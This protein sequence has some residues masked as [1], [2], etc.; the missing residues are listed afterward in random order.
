MN[1]ENLALLFLKFCLTILFT[2]LLI[3]S[4]QPPFINDSLFRFSLSYLPYGT[5]ISSCDLDCPLLQ[6]SITASVT[7]NLSDSFPPSIK[8]CHRQQAI[9]ILEGAIATLF[10]L[11]IDT[12]DARL[13]ATSAGEWKDRLKE[14]EVETGVG[15]ELKDK[16]GGELARGEQERQPRWFRRRGGWQSER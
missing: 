6:I 2:G 13:A 16:L 4:V 12:Q 14:G 5:E 7:R 11:N 15:G 8:A 10:L 9:C 1:Q 3:H